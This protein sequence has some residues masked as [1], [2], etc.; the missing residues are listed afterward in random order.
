M[1][2]LVTTNKTPFVIPAIFP[3]APLK[4]WSFS[5]YRR[6]ATC[7][8]MVA[9]EKH[10]GKV[11]ANAA[12]QEGQAVHKTGED[13]VTA[14]T[15]SA[16]VPDRFQHVA[17]HA[18]ACR[19]DK[20]AEVELEWTFTK[21]WQPTGWFDPDA[22]VR[23]KSDVRRVLIPGK[24]GKP[25]IEVEITD[26]KTGKPYA[27]WDEEQ[28]ELLALGEFIMHG[29]KTVKTKFAHLDTGDESDGLF[30]LLE[31]KTLIKVWNARVKG[32]MA[33][34]RFLPKPQ[35]NVCGWCP[36]SQRKGGPCEY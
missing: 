30:D 1:G 6:Y 35:P 36:F 14:K 10:K 2:R 3:F 11:A 34:K 7:P 15:K 19:A 24:K 16:K 9:L 21:A 25:P 27:R 20:S 5:L 13:F 32:L 22:W 12:M 18:K 17:G 26:W 8:R 31:A 28:A 33:D 23:M 4:A 29:T